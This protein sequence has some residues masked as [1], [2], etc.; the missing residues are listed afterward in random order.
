M[1]GDAAGAGLTREDGGEAFI[2]DA[3]EEGGFAQAG[4]AQDGNA[5]GVDIGPL[6]EGVQDAGEASR[7]DGDGTGALRARGEADVAKQAA[8]RGGILLEVAVAGGGDSKAVLRGGGDVEGGCIGAAGE[9]VGG[10]ELVSGAVDVAG[11]SGDFRVGKEGVVAREVEAEEAGVRAGMV[12]EG[13]QDR[14]GEKRADLQRQKA[15]S[16]RGVIE[17]RG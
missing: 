14:K 9:G 8:A 5:A 4:V 7:P 6:E 2:G 1:G 10:D 11:R 13:E 16:C 15:D 17:E 3:G 12:G